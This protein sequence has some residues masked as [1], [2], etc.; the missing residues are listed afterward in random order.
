[1]SR[2]SWS[3]R[4]QGGEQVEVGVEILNLTNHRNVIGIRYNDL[5]QKDRDMTGIGLLP[6]LDVTVRF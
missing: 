1:M 6:S 3:T 2:V 5:Y 4:L